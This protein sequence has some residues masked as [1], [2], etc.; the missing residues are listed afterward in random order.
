MSKNTQNLHE[1]LGLK[2]LVEESVPL[3]EFLQSLKEHPYRVDTAAARLVRAVK[4]KG[5]LSPEEA[6]PERRKYIQLLKDLHI[7]AYKAF[8]H[9]RGAQRFVHRVM[10]HYESAAKHGYQMRQGLVLLS[11]PGAGKTLLGDAISGV[12]EG[13]DIWAVE[14]CPIG[15][16]PINLLTL[17]SP[18]QLVQLSEALGMREEKDGKVVDLLEQLMLTAQEPCG[19][20]FKAIN[21]G[22]NGEHPSLAEMKVQRVRLSSRTKGITVWS[23]SQDTSTSELHGALIQ[24]NRG[25]V[26]LLE[27]FSANGVKPG[28]VSELSL[29]LEA[30]DSRRVPSNQ[31]THCHPSN[32]WTSLDSNIIIESNPGAWGAFLKS[33]TDRDAYIRRTRVLYMPYNTV[34]SE[35]EEAY[36]DELKKRLEQPE[37][38]PLALR[39]IAILAVASRMI[40]DSGKLGGL[41]IA[42]RVRLYDGEQI[43][44]PKTVSTVRDTPNPYTA[45]PTSAVNQTSE[46][47]RT[48]TVEDIWKLA[49]EEEGKFGLN[50]GFMLAA[51]SRISEV[52]LSG[53][54][55]S[56]PA[57]HVLFWLNSI[58]QMAAQVPDISKEQK[59][60]Y[61]R[62]LKFLKPAAAKT[63]PA[64]DGES[65]MEFEYRRLL[66]QQF[67][68]VFAPDYDTRATN[69]SDKY[70]LHAMASA[71]GK[72]VF[73]QATKRKLPV[74]T[75]FL[76]KIETAMGKTGDDA[77]K[78]RAT[79]VSEKANLIAAQI[80]KANDSGASTD[81]P[82]E[83]HWTLHPEIKKAISK[84][85]DADIATKVSKLLT[86]EIGLSEEEEKLHKDSLERLSALGYSEANLEVALNYFKE[87]E[88]WKAS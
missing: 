29:L 34:A 27:A 41:D 22:T 4:D 63:S 56:A 37:F 74:D 42:T 57:L 33:Q 15:E 8:D 39:L 5:V 16:N 17:L 69:L 58:I 2:R 80:K 23:P 71:Q 19:H 83:I 3:W 85:L 12:L 6:E 62:C 64:P 47:K 60:V 84:I 11:G 73:D 55:K 50:M 87:N 13:E 65:F 26:R 25:V 45:F 18:T 76:A 54:K 32:G 43:V 75:V 77:N 24:A 86:T 40:A 66:R 31:G 14:G 67:L 35:E 1:L 53:P 20:C 72:E 82:L 81:G 10:N 79:L 7:P 88:L 51:L 52:A 68:S 61:D 78:F 21:Q 44:L 48:A 49:G 9:V 30:T 38:D 59:D 36:K 28:E 46:E 70:W